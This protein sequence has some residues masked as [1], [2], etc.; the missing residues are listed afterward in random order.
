MKIS[1]EKPI[2]KI[3]LVSELHLLF[4]RQDVA[5]LLIL[6]NLVKIIIMLMLKVIMSPIN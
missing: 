2:S 6:A 1:S 3:F 5:V 4:G